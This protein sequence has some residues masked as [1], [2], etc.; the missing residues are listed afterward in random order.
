MFKETS[1]ALSD[2]VPIDYSKPSLKTKLQNFPWWFAALIGIAIAMYIAIATT[3]SYSE[4]F[5]FIRAGLG[6]TITTTLTAFLFAIL[7]GLV[8]GLGRIS[9]SVFFRNLATLYVEFIRG[10]PMLVLI[11]FIAFVGLPAV[12]GGLN[13]L[14]H[15]F[16]SIN[17]TF[18]ATPLLALENK[19]INMNVRAI[20]ALTVTYGAFLAE[21]FRAGIQSISKG[22]M[23]AARSQ[24]M[25]YWQ[26]MY[27]IILPQAIRNVLPALGND[28][29][30]MLKDSSLVSVLAVRD[31]TQVAR[32]YA[33]RSFRYDEAYT[34]LVVMYLTMTVILSLL[35]KYL[36]RRSSQNE[37]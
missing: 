28:F 10:V 11:F 9:N 8:T 34:T 12:V 2:E 18:A 23:E 26:A 1:N 14:G 3:P 27:Y 32:L 35:V 36:E 19:N 6:I 29:V 17:F 24:G 22:Q 7:L 13:A 20:I 31:I 33:G 37:R 30:A 15:W 21:I 25:S 16:D 5:V 4:A